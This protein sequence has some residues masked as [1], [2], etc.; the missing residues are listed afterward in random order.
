MRS[1]RYAHSF[2][3]IRDLP[4]ALKPLK[5]LAYNFRW[6]WHHETQRV[7]RD[8]DQEIWEETNHNPVELLNLLSDD[9]MRA[10]CEDEVY[11]ARLKVCIEDLND[12]LGADTW[13]DQK[14]PGERE[15]TRVAYFCAEFGISESLPIYSGGL[16]VLA[17]DHLKAA[18][19]LGIPLVG[20]GLL[21]ARGYFRQFL[22]ADA[23]QQ[24]HYPNY[25]FFRMPLVLVRGKDGKP[26]RIQV[27]F[28]DR[29]VTCQIW[30]AQ[31][32]RVSLYLLDSNIL[33][34][35]PRDQS[36]TDTLYGGDEEMR[37]RQESIL[38]IGGFRALEALD[39]V[40]TVCHMNE[41]HAAFLSLERLRHFMSEHNC[42]L[43][44]ARKCV[45]AGNVFTTHTPV[46]AG[47]D[48]FDSSMLERY[49]SK[50]VAQLGLPFDQFLRLG[51]INKDNNSERFNMAVLAME[52]SNYVNGVSR[53]H[54]EVTREMFQARW[55]NYPLQEV[56]VDAITNGIHT[57]TFLAPSMAQLF[58]KHFGS[59]WVDQAG[60]RNLWKRVADIPDR[61]LWELRENLRGD[62][63]RFCRRHVRRR[64][65][66][67]SA[68]AADMQ[69][70]NDIL[71]PRILTIGFARRFATYKRATLL[72]RDRERLKSI[73]H[74]PER[75]VQFVFAGKSHPKDDGGK[76]LI[77]DIV[78]YLRQEGART[79][80]VFLE[81]YDMGV[82]RQMVQGVD[83]WLNNPRRPMEASGTSG[84]KVVP[85]GALNCSILDGWWAEG[86]QRG[87]G[88]AIGD[89][90]Q[91]PDEGHQD[92]LDSRALYS[93]IE[94]EIAP[95]FY[96]RNDHGIPT[97][98]VEM[99]KQS[100]MELAPTFSTL[101]M[102]REYTSRFYVPASRSF[103]NLTED[104][105]SRAKTA[106][107]WRD[108][109]TSSW[110]KVR[111]LSVADNVGQAASIGAQFEVTAVVELDGLNPNDVKAQVMVGLVSSNRELTEIE[112][113]DLDLQ[114]SDGS[115]HI[116]RGVA[117]CE[118][119]GHRGYVVRVVPF[120]EDVRIPTELS[121]AA[122]EP[123]M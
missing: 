16:G 32:G 91:N 70:V 2:E 23:W 53:L 67:N 117:T 122:W 81:D 63:V 17:G 115:K 78:H 104:Q 56:P 87:V 55:P 82:A 42:E 25:D 61:E 120:H 52:N 29:T 106:L 92:W 72:F 96:M 90:N 108:K 31:V 93:L 38:G 15:K 123:V 71:D 75:P 121:L 59:N 110:D 102:V 19:D 45:V 41:G 9:R 11:L 86:Y 89:H 80:M 49:V 20:V 66:L 103:Q 33:E 1:P 58:D 22:S 4:D 18:S 30:K 26:M 14:F 54:A 27:E 114:S 79:R 118:A 101:R 57:L 112:V 68:G 6:T 84:M 44:V 64:M 13:F 28:P 36:I 12:Y 62:F 47:F 74:H 51:R 99:M 100:M 46:P 85:N 48:L 21:Y 109:V 73:L 35:A 107:V 34:N 97:A 95:T 76:K 69:N 77:Q 40:P 50:S 39:L 88:W 3:V 94:T 98:W 7:F 8:T 119:P 116:F 65:K 111:V 83:V 105:L 37:I 10:L 60:D 24:E 113:H 5:D 43:R